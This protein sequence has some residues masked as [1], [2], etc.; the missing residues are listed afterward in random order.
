MCCILAVASLII[1]KIISRLS[2]YD[3]QGKTKLSQTMLTDN[4]ATTFADSFS[5]SKCEY[6]DSTRMSTMSR[7]ITAIWINDNCYNDKINNLCTKPVK[8]LVQKVCGIEGSVGFIS[9]I[10][11]ITGYLAN[12]ESCVDFKWR[13]T[14][15]C[16]IA[17]DT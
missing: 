17:R 10:H 16:A 15:Y 1:I 12:V 5:I 2:F 8:L 6:N 14:T 4:H 11:L 13:T 9:G 3:T 7:I